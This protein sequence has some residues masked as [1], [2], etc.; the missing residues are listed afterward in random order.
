M[1]PELELPLLADF[2]LYCLLML[3]CSTGSAAIGVV[4]AGSWLDQ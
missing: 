4:I 3:A 2:K 1:F